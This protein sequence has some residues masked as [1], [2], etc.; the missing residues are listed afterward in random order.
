MVNKPVLMFVY[1]FL[2]SINLALVFVMTEKLGSKFNYIFGSL[3]SLTF[4]A[5]CRVI[6]ELLVNKRSLLKLVTTITKVE[7]YL[8]RLELVKF[9]IPGL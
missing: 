7:H 1:Q 4:S 5:T 8:H 6:V 2:A 9:N 3:L